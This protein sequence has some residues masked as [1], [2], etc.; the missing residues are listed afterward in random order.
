MLVL[1]NIRNTNRY[2]I[3]IVGANNKRCHTT[4]M[5]IRKNPGNAV[6]FYSKEKGN[7]LEEICIKHFKLYGGNITSPTNALNNSILEG[8]I[9]I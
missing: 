6:L 1:I 9:Q 2:N 5:Y 7:I 3:G 8:I 4:V